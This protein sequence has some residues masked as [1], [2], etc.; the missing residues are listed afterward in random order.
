MN[1]DWRRQSHHSQVFS[2]LGCVLLVAFNL[3]TLEATAA[4]WP[5][6]LTLHADSH[7]PDGHYGIVVTTSS[8]VD[9][10]A[11]ILLPEEGEVFV[12]YFAN[13]QTH[14]LLGKVKHFEYVE[15]EN[16][17]HLDTDWT[18]DSSFCVATYWGRYGFAYATIL[19]L[20]GE[21]FTHT[22]IGQHIQKA[23]DLLIKKKA[24]DT[25]DVYP[26][27]SIELARK[28]RVYATASN[29]P[30]QLEDVKTYYA[31]FQGTFDVGSKKWIRSATRSLTAE[32]NE[33]LD[34]ASTS[35]SYEQLVVS[36]DAF[37]NWDGA[38]E[39]M[40]S[41][42]KQLFRSEETKCKYLDDHLNDVYNAIR[43]LLSP[44]DFAKIKRDQIEWLKQRDTAN[45]VAEKSKLAEERTEALQYLVWPDRKETKEQ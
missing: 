5:E 7:S 15:G 11:T 21:S 44:A 29:N 12:D 38:D 16:H 2:R 14:R 13:L 17:S 25:I 40:P 6:H 39:P 8:H 37:K 30:K 45:S 43:L 42:D 36:P 4:D 41:D 18:S 31:L 22:D 10:G 33:M 28:L 34:K 3:T 32:E 26:H 35:Y 20:K 1:F 23:I 27:F 9:D 24:R 19:E